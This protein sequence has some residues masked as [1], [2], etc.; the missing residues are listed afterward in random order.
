MKPLKLGP[1]LLNTYALRPPPKVAS[2][3][4]RTA[5]HR[6]WSEAVIERDGG[7]VKCGVPKGVSRLF[8]DHIT[9][10]SDG[11]DPLDPRNGQTLCSRC[12]AIKTAQARGERARGG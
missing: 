4:Y 11:G 9:E 2:A 3:H 6:A 12:H 7:C 8:A 10:I 1:A 5:E